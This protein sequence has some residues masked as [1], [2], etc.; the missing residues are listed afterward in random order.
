MSSVSRPGRRRRRPARPA[1]ARLRAADEAGAAAT[2]PPR[3]PRAAR[4]LRTRAD[5]DT[6]TAGTLTI[7]TG[8]P[9]YEPWFTDDDPTNG[10]GFESAVAYAVAEQL[11]YAKDEVTWARR[12]FNS[13]DRARAPSRTTSTSTRS[14]S[15]TSARRPSTSPP[16]TTTSPRPSSPSR[17]ARP[18]SAKDLADLAKLKLGAQVGTTS[19]NGDH[20]RDQ[21]ADAKPA[22]FNDNDQAKLALNNGQIDALVVDLP[23]GAV[24]G[25]RRAEGRRRSSASSPATGSGTAE[26]FGFVLE[27]GSPLT[28]CVTRRS[29]RC[30]PTA[31]SKHAGGAVADRRGR[32]PVLLK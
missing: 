6:K 19:Y 4:R 30:A 10:K 32:R 31:R 22:V 27:K 24:P 11:G 1:A 25:R 23:T 14:R 16:A 18:P 7:A 9:A 15:P 26:Q 2:P 28:T 17:A 3:R 5:L 20:R 29:T 13:V 12:R 8:K 21:A